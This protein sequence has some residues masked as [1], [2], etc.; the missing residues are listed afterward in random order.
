MIRIPRN[1]ALST[2]SN[3]LNGFATG[4]VRVGKSWRANAVRRLLLADNTKRSLS[5]G[6]PVSAGAAY[7]RRAVACPVHGQPPG[8]HRQTAHAPT[9]APV[10]RDVG[11][12]SFGHLHGAVRNAT[13][14]RAPSCP[15]A[16][17]AAFDAA[18]PT[19]A[20]DAT[21]APLGHAG[22][23]GLSS[24]LRSRLRAPFPR[25]RVSTSPGTVDTNTPLKRVQA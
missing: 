24:I 14:E 9:A 6:T 13:L 23:T 20:P 12:I 19:A 2:S 16:Q 22:V 15:P 4:S 11:G 1:A 7:G 10:D 21:A 3:R 17:P 5:S 18:I 25:L 8:E